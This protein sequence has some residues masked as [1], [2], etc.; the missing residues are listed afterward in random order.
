[1][2]S[3]IYTLGSLF[4]WN[5]A[6]RTNNKLSYLSHSLCTHSLTERAHNRLVV[7]AFLQ[8][9]LYKGCIYIYTA[10]KLVCHF[11]KW[12][13]FMDM[14]Y[15]FS[16]W[17]ANINNATVTKAQNSKVW[18]GAQQKIRSYQLSARLYSTSIIYS[19]LST[20]QMNIYIKFNT[21]GVLSSGLA[22]LIR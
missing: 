3:N 17:Y 6:L 5:H 8:F 12:H 21:H 22:I 16:K 15:I 1:M 14:Y 19:W 18:Q 13:K 20:Q 7:D 2:I 11:L 10:S 4:W 9:L